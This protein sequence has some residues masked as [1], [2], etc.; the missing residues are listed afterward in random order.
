M[1]RSARLEPGP[2]AALRLRLPLAPLLALS[3]TLGSNAEPTRVG[4]AEGASPRSHGIDSVTLFSL[5]R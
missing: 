2:E 5:T 1:R 3:S 4:A